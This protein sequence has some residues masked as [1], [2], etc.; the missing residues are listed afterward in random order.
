MFLGSMLGGLLEL[1][2]GRQKLG[3]VRHSPHGSPQIPARGVSMRRGLMLKSRMF[4]A[5]CTTICTCNT[6]LVKELAVLAGAPVGA[7]IE[8]HAQSKFLAYGASWFR[9]MR[10]AVRT[11]LGPWTVS[12]RRFCS[13]RCFQEWQIRRCFV[14]CVQSCCFST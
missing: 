9:G 8:S 2:C 3:H 1:I 11:L 4:T 7:R 14:I 13:R 6:A 5:T 10:P 12:I